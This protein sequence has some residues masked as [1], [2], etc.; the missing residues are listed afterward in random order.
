MPNTTRV[1]NKVAEM[2]LKYITL[3]EEFNNFTILK[4]EIIN[5]SPTENWTSTS[6]TYLYSIDMQKEVF[7]IFLL[8]AVELVKEI[9]SEIDVA[10]T[11][12]SSDLYD[13]ADQGSDSE[14]D[15]YYFDFNVLYDDEEVFE[16]FKSEITKK[17]EKA[18]NGYYIKGFTIN[19]ND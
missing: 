17:I 5:C 11:Y 8:Q 14:L 13:L 2:K 15:Q 7:S 9:T 12:N 19:D 4:D 1:T 3:R 6:K 18:P 10:I 16:V